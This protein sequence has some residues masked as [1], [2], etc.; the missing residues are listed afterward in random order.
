MSSR[1]EVH[2]ALFER[3]ASCAAFNTASRR[4]RLINE[5]TRE[6]CPA[7][8]LGGGSDTPIAANI[9]SSWGEA[10]V[11]KLTFEVTIYTYSSEDSEVT[12][13]TEL[14][15]LIDKVVAL[16]SQE[17]EL[18]D[19]GGLVEYVVINPEAPI[20]TDCGLYEPFAQ[21]TIPLLVAW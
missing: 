7:L 20:V 1:E 19:L 3:L 15:E 9:V 10:L 12:P 8:Y 5:V 13:T 16:F 4:L 14:N 18:D 21:A 11:H 2:Q 6:M 17:H